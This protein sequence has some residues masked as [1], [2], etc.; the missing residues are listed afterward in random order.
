MFEVAIE[1]LKDFVTLIP[2]I[3]ALILVMN[4]CSSLLFGRC[5]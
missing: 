2:G 1:L 5:D 4:I 3:T